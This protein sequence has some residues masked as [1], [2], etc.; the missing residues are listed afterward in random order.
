MTANRFVPWDVFAYQRLYLFLQV[1]DERDTL[2]QRLRELEAK[3]HQ[4]E[5]EKAEAQ[6][7]AE[8]K[9]YAAPSRTADAAVANDHASASQQHILSPAPAAKPY[10]ASEYPTPQIIE[11][12]AAETSGATTVEYHSPAPPK[13]VEMVDEALQ[14]DVLLSPV[15]GQYDLVTTNNKKTH[16]SDEE[17]IVPVL[18]YDRMKQELEQSRR[19][20]AMLMQENALGGA[21]MNFMQQQ[22][23]SHQSKGLDLTALGSAVGASMVGLD[24]SASSS[25]TTWSTVVETDTLMAASAKS[26]LGNHNGN[27]QIL[28][29]RRSISHQIQVS[30]TTSSGT[31]SPLPNHMTSAASIMSVESSMAQL[32]EYQ[33]KIQRLEQENHQLKHKV[34]SSSLLAY[35]GIYGDGDVDGRDTLVSSYNNSQHTPMQ[36]S[37]VE[38]LFNDENDDSSAAERRKSDTGDSNHSAQK[39]NLVTNKAVEFGT[40]PLRNTMLKRTNSRTSMG[41][42]AASSADKSP[43]KPMTRASTGSNSDNHA[44]GLKAATPSSQ[45]SRMSTGGASSSTNNSATRTV[46]RQNSATPLTPQGSSSSASSSFAAADRNQQSPTSLTSSSGIDGVNPM[47]LMMMSGK[48]AKKDTP[49]TTPSSSSSNA[50]KSPNGGHSTS[51]VSNN[52]TTNT[53]KNTNKVRNSISTRPAIFTQDMLLQQPGGTEIDFEDSDNEDPNAEYAAT[54]HVDEDDHLEQEKKHAWEDYMQSFASRQISSEGGGPSFPLSAEDLLQDGDDGEEEMEGVGE[55]TAEDGDVGRGEDDDNDVEGD[56]N[57]TGNNGSNNYSSKASS[58]AKAHSGSLHPNMDDESEESGPAY[59]IKKQH[60]QHS[61]MTVLTGPSAS[62]KKMHLPT[63]T[64]LEDRGEGEEGESLPESASISPLSALTPLSTLGPATTFASLPGGVR[65][66]QHE[67]TYHELDDSDDDDQQ[68]GDEDLQHHVNWDSALSNG[69]DYDDEERPSLYP[70]SRASLAD[71]DDNLS[72]MVHDA[73]LSKLLFGDPSALLVQYIETQRFD[74]LQELLENSPELTTKPLTLDGDA[75]LSARGLSSLHYACHCNAVEIVAYLVSAMHVSVHVIDFEETPPLH[76]CTSSETIQLL[77]AQGG[78]AN[79]LNSKGYTALHRY[80]MQMYDDKK[81]PEDHHKS[82]GASRNPGHVNH[83]VVG[84]VV[85][86]TEREQ[87]LACIQ[88]ILQCGADPMI[89][90]PVQLRN[91]VHIAAVHADL[92]LLTLLFQDA[93]YTLSLDAGDE[94]DNSPLIFA[95]ASEKIGGDSH[96]SSGVGQQMKVF[97]L[98]IS[99]GAS[100]LLCNAR[101]LTALHLVCANRYLSTLGYAELMVDMLLGLGADPNALDPDGCTPLIVACAFREWNLCKLLLEAGGDMNIP[102]SMNSLF[103]QG[104]RG[105]SMIIDGGSALS[106]GRNV[107][108]SVDTRDQKTMDLMSRIDCTASDLMPR[109]PRYTLFG[110]IRVIQT[111]IPGETRDCCMNCGQEFHHSS[112]ALSM[113]RIM[114]TG[115]HH[116]RHCNRV[117]CQTCS[118]KEFPRGQFPAFVQAEYTES[119]L[120]ACVVCAEVLFG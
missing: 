66:A 2:A 111:R 7:V 39:Q 90:E 4:L 113:F 34:R 114:T 89:P 116:C 37:R 99:K 22:Q 1:I 11:G 82:K 84:G 87:W 31:T 58:K 69:N 115:K 35:D 20:L 95:V 112:S 50:D 23:Q 77:M 107:L 70:I 16:N 108:K 47:K 45:T 13:R 117:I 59:P 15:A 81:S 48:N 109:Q 43:K 24:G 64:G 68:T 14:A 3:Y 5:Q 10:A 44:Q 79:A 86:L 52:A 12:K 72:T 93:Q 71:D 67:E 96:S 63:E 76:Y 104:G 92:D 21:A 91:A 6:A 53:G 80:L 60:L 25:S 51:A 55:V 74:A 118:P 33:S 38:Q 57:H 61:P 88:T 65:R 100:A 36:P 94:E 9:A 105:S 101:G 41:P 56:E 29:V 40:N 49:S 120:R 8:S 18:E 110:S 97:S 19:L 27:Q 28:A 98:L 62:H 32:A 103:L 17:V 26:P 85:L 54:A 106:D 73:S 46:K 78:D 83:P 119:S 75:A 42:S 102:C 30:S